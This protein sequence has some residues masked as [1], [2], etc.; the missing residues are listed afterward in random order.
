MYGKTMSISDALDLVARAFRGLEVGDEAVEQPARLVA[1]VVTVV[2]H[3][4]VER[5]PLVLG[6]GVDGEVRLGEHDGP[7][8]AGALELVEARVHGRQAGVAHEL[9]ALVLE[10]GAIEQQLRIAAAAAQIADEMQTVHVRSPQKA[11]RRSPAPNNPGCAP[12]CPPCGG[13]PSR[14]RSLNSCNTPLGPPCTYACGA[15][16]RFKFG[17]GCPRKPSRSG[18]ARSRFCLE[19]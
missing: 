18:A 6:P 10:P 17:A 19:V 8:E 4:D 2:A 15:E 9:Q 1:V 7:G 12:A 16:H 11:R 3:V 13:I 14:S 5:Q